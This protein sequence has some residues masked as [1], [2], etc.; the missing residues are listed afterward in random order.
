MPLQGKSEEQAHK[1]ERLT[2]WQ[3]ER[4]L[5][6]FQVEAAEALA[7][8]GENFE[9]QA[10]VGGDVLQVEA[11]QVGVFGRRRR[12]GRAEVAYSSGLDFPCLQAAE[13]LE[14]EM[15]AEDD[16]AGIHGAG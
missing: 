12:L 8:R 11:D 1:T 9:H 6:Q 15:Q 14:A 3:T 7:V 4:A 2:N 10:V 5:Q 16:L 13:D